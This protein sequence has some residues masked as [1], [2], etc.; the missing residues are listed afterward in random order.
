[1]HVVNQTSQTDREEPCRLDTLGLAD[2]YEHDQKAIY[3]EFK[4]H[5]VRDE[6]GWYETGLLWRGAHP[7]LPSNKQGSIRH[8]GSLK[9]KLG[10][11]GLTNEHDQIIRDQ[12]EQGVIED[13][14]PEPAGREFY[15]PTSLWFG[16]KLRAPNYGWFATLQQELDQMQRMFVPRP[17]A[18]K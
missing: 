10:R 13:C 4:E 17:C 15:I 1:M 7:V 3:D 12:R 9:K 11:Q 2:S 18:T 6:E 16:K 5:L 14:P 8:L